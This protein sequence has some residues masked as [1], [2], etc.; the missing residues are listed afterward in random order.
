MK[1]EI[2]KLS[3]EQKTTI[4]SIFLNVLKNVYDMML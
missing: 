4:D 2:F 1:S 3:C